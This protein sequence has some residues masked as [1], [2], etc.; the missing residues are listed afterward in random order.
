MNRRMATLVLLMTLLTAT[1]CTSTSSEPPARDAEGITDISESSY[2][3]EYNR[4]Y[5]IMND[6]KIYEGQLL[7]LRC[8]IKPAKESEGYLCVIPDGTGCCSLQLELAF[9]EVIPEDAPKEACILGKFHS[10]VRDGYRYC[11]IIDAQIVT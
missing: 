1:G 3:M 9:C 10:Y 7:R 8:K 6:W 2:F 5:N 4:L 11:Q